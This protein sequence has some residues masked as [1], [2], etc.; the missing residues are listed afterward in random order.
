MVRN[1]HFLQ[2]ANQGAGRRINLLL[3]WSRKTPSKVSLHLQNPCQDHRPATK[4]ACHIWQQADHGLG[5]GQVSSSHESDETITGFFPCEHFF[6]YRNIIY[7]R[8][9]SGVG[10]KN[11]PLIELHTDA[12]CHKSPNLITNLATLLLNLQC[13][14][15]RFLTIPK[16]DACDRCCISIIETCCNAHIA[17][18][19]RYSI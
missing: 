19:W 2:F 4:W 13:D 10:H 8:I 7:T 12:I 1:H 18:V 17:L 5:C 3:W 9:G 14:N 16:S 11:K 6:E 15:H